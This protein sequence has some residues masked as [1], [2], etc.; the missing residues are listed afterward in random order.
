VPVLG[1]VENMSYFICPNCDEKHELFQRSDKW[2]APALEG[3]PILG[4]IP[5]ARAI[6]KGINQANPLMHHDPDSLQAK[7]FMEITAVL[8]HKLGF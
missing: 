8:Q 3:T 7:A 1:I 2:R 6:S 5:L 4:R